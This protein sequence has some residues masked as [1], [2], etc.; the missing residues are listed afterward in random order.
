MHVVYLL[1]RRRRHH[2]SSCLVV[3]VTSL[4]LNLMAAFYSV[5]MKQTI[6]QFLF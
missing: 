3:V 6:W 2:P 1:S 4:Q 5:Q